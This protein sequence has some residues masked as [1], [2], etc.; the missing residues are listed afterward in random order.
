MAQLNRYV[1]GLN[2]NGRSAV[3][4]DGVPNHQEK[5][6]FF[7]RG[8][9]W[10]TRET[11]VDNTVPGDR[12]LDGELA[13]R[14]P[15]P[16]GMLVRALEMWPEKP[17]HGEEFAAL[18]RE[19]GQQ[20]EANDEERGRSATMHRT[21]TLDVIH[22]I[23]GEI[24]L[25]LDEGEVLMKPSDTVVIKGVNHGWSNRGTEPC[26]LIGSMLD[27]KPLDAKPLD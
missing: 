16:N 19:V 10:K 3:I 12:S 11:P 27:A 22:V 4:T 25:V 24:Y 20:H 14:S 15:F 23:R 18:N 8:T 1:V 7:W 2:E 26:L 5:P 13:A 21:D 17:E 9:L 6:D